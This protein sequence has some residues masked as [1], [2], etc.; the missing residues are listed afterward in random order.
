MFAFNWSPSILKKGTSPAQ[1][2]RF[3]KCAPKPPTEPQLPALVEKY[4]NTLGS[5]ENAVFT[6]F[7]IKRQHYLL[8]YNIC[9][10]SFKA[11][12]HIFV[13]FMQKKKKMKENTK[14]CTYVRQ[15][16]TYNSKM[17]INTTFLPAT[18]LLLPFVSPGKLSTIYFNEFFTNFC[19]LLGCHSVCVLY[20]AFLC[21]FC[22]CCFEW[23]P[24]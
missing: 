18:F 3:S 9:D 8:D 5:K 7:S 11:A 15:T 10:I 24:E 4:W 12:K 2:K 19:L 16:R 20:M 14:S 13:G 21:C 1:Q 23:H 6:S 17:F 22:C